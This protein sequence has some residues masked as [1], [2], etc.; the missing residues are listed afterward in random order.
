MAHL[1]SGWL[2]AIAFLVAGF[3]NALGRPAVRR[4]FV[5][6]GYPAWWCRVTGGLEIVVAI[7]LCLAA[8]RTAGLILGATI[9]GAAIVTVLRWRDF[10]HL[11]PLGAFAA[12]LALAASLPAVGP[13]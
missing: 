5:R 3:V 4:D 9:I 8:T 12:L 13:A 1:V 2:A 7:L 6:W 10:P 11:L